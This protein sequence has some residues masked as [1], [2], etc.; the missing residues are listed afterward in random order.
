ML[1]GGRKSV[2][3]HAL[4]I[5]DSFLLKERVL[6]IPSIFLNYLLAR[7][8]PW[9]TGLVCW[10]RSASNL[11]KE[12]QYTFDSQPDI[13][14]SG[15]MGA[16][17]THD[18]T[19][20]CKILKKNNKKRTHNPLWAHSFEDRFLFFDN[21]RAFQRNSLFNDKEKKMKKESCLWASIWVSS[22]VCRDFS[23][24]FVWSPDFFRSAHALLYRALKALF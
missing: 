15:Q 13:L 6:K 8:N 3:W 1:S 14:Y 9:R 10:N 20:L 19:C 17:V 18:V 4:R 24:S 22:H 7:Q 5:F 12:L 23:I 16:W 2:D 11:C 21:A